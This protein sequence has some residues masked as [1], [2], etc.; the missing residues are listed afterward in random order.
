M[1]LVTG[2]LPLLLR[3]P[4]QSREAL[5]IGELVPYQLNQGRLLHRFCTPETPW[6]CLDG[7]SSS[8]PCAASPRPA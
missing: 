1:E 6:L 5:P 7:V 8:T 4:L 3:G 2:L